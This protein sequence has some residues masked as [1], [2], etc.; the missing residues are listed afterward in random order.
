M[1]TVQQEYD[2]YAAEIDE[3]V[4]NGWTVEYV[5]YRMEWLWVRNFQLPGHSGDR[6]AMKRDIAYAAAIVAT[7]RKEPVEV[8][9]GMD[10]M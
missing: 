1:R 6:T 8:S 5:A 2:D 4:A 10:A 9:W 7:L 3:G